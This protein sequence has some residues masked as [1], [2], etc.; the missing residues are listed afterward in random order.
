MAKRMFLGFLLL[1]AAG[2][3]AWYAGQDESRRRYI[4]HLVKQIP[5]LPG[6][7]YI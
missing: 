7:Y 1:F 2:L 3:V 6:R 5:A 4:L